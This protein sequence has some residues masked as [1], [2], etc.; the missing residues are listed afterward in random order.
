VGRSE[1]A[2]RAVMQVRG[3]V[4]G[5]Y[6]EGVLGEAG[7]ILGWSGMGKHIVALADVALRFSALSCP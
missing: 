5:C 4:D 7:E 3:G 1:G 2:R 6:G